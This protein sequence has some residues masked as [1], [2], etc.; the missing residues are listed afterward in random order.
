MLIYVKFRSE[1]GLDVYTCKLTL[2]QGRKN[3]T[4]DAFIDTTF[5]QDIIL[6]FE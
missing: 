1:L 5:E 3:Y 6:E 2:G 4:C